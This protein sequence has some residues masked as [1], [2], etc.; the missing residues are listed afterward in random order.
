MVIDNWLW[1][2]AVGDRP[3]HIAMIP[4]P[5]A[6]P[7]E[8]KWWREM[9][10]SDGGIRFLLMLPGRRNLLELRLQPAEDHGDP[11]GE[12]RDEM[13]LR[14]CL[15]PG[16]DGLHVGQTKESIVMEHHPGYLGRL[17]ATSMRTRPVYGLGP[18][19]EGGDDRHP[20]GEPESRHPILADHRLQAL[21][22]RGIP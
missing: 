9:L 13:F 21:Y 12:S 2:P 19:A 20:A 5:E 8:L 11:C 3:S 4:W 22:H 16:H 17:V 15:M 1:L 6:G 10:R 14:C 7:A 18:D